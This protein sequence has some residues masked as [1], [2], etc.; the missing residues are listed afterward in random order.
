MTL[1]VYRFNGTRW[2]DAE[3]VEA[4][5]RAAAL[6]AQCGVA[7]ERVELAL[8]EAP[9]QFRVYYTPVSR[10]LVRR[11]EPRKPALF[12]VEDTRNQPAFDAE[13]IGLSN[14]ARRPELVNTVW[15]AYGARDVAH[16]IAHELVHVLSDSG[17]HSGEA[18][19]LMQIETSPQ[20]TVLSP[21]QCERI[22]ARGEANGLLAP[23]SR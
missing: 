13:A 14:S 17:E 4:V 15:V 16:A 12:F 8:I 22:V 23:V 20:N 9:P 5:P 1:H 10:E 3:I 18:G 7:V 11:L 21:A 6:L 19:N 2:R